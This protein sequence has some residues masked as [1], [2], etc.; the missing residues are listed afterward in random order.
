[1]GEAVANETQTTL[2][3]VLLNGIEDL[4]LGYFQLGVGPTRDLNDHVE[5]TIVLVVK[6]RNVVEGGNDGPVVFR[7]YAMV[8]RR[9]GELTSNGCPRC[10]PISTEGVGSTDDTGGVF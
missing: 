6:E 1:M 3:D 10:Y 4:I 2:F 8:W 7:I 5:D 9:V